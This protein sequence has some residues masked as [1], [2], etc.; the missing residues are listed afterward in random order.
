MKITISNFGNSFAEIRA[1]F[2]YV[3]PALWHKGINDLIQRT[4]HYH[5]KF[6]KRNINLM[7]SDTILREIIRTNFFST[8]TRTYLL[9]TLF[10]HFRFSF[11]HL[12]S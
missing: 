7:I 8:L 9:F 6:F 3:L 2:F 10:T 5:I 12:S 4:F 1:G 11:F